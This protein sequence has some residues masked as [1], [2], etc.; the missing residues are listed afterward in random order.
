MERIEIEVTGQSP[1]L[2]HAFPM[3]AG[4]GIDKWPPDKQAEFHVYRRPDTSAIYVPGVNF[5]RALVAGAAFSK[6]KG[7]ASLQKIVAAA[8]F[9]I[10]P[11]IDLIPQEYSVDS[12][13]VV[14]PA[15][16]GRIVRHRA[17]FDDWRLACTLEFD[18]KLMDWKQVRKVVDDTGA[19]IGL[20]DY[21]P[22]KKGPFGRFVVT[23]WNR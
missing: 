6:G 17:R 8:L 1:L 7:R 10:E 19:R 21:R 12:R 9:V 22:E 5:Q 18:E 14:I 3:V 23:R 16:R 2:M 15:T 4:D 11:Y 13:A 20:L